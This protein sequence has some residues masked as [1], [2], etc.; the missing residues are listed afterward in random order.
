VTASRRQPAH[1]RR[2]RSQEELREA[3][4]ALTGRAAA[5]MRSLV[6]GQDWERW[7]R[8][9]A[10]LPG[11]SFTNVMLIAAQR[12][13]ATMVD[14]YQEWLARGRQ[15]RKGEP[16]I[17]VI[18]ERAAAS[19]NRGPAMPAGTRAADRVAQL[20]P[21]PQLTYV[22]DISQT[23]GQA[24]GGRDGP[25]TDAGK[26]PPGL[27]DALT[28]LARR[29]GFTV[30]RGDCGLVRGV[31]TWDGR[32]IRIRADLSGPETAGALAHELG[33]VLAHDGLA[34]LP[35]AS[36]AGCGGIQKVEADSIAF[37]VAAH[38]GMDTSD[39]S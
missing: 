6:T 25:G 11:W 16:G 28:W 14:G 1:G 36:T 4:A 18:A 33:H 38:L 3:V 27:W 19:A 31:T 12:P 8:L 17:Q 15:V 29:E 13:G 21:Q 32:R 37:I 30:G 39:N 35:G 9:A 34:I 20:Q 26:P 24:D 10:R 23:S 22:W 5:Q 7:L 2:A